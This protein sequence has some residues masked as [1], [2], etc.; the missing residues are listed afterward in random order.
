MP[1]IFPFQKD[2]LVLQPAKAP[3]ILPLV[4]TSAATALGVWL[5]RRDVPAGWLSAG[6][7]AAGCALALAHLLLNRTYVEMTLEG[8]TLGSLFG[9]RRLKWSQIE[10]CDFNR[11][12]VEI[13]YVQ[14]RRVRKMA[15]MPDAYRMQP[16]EMAQLLNQWRVRAARGAND[17]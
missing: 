2:S 7:G 12:G 13:R 6:L 4:L 10:W 11:Q 8:L 1:T 16:K 15:V 14:D 9:V 5:I 3:L 17:T